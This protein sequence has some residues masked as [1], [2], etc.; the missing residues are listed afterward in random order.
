[1]SNI[2]EDFSTPPPT[3]GSGRNDKITLLSQ[4][5]HSAVSA[6]GRKRSREIS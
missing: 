2:G 4:N 5:C 1:L 3:G 6:I